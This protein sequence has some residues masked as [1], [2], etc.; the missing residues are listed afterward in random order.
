M[1]TLPRVISS[2]QQRPADINEIVVYRYKVRSPSHVAFSMAK[3]ILLQAGYTMYQDFVQE[4]SKHDFIANFETDARIHQARETWA[5]VDATFYSFHLDVLF[6]AE[7]L[8]YEQNFTGKRYFYQLWAELDRPGMFLSDSDCEGEEEV[9]AH[10]VCYGCD[11]PYQNSW[12]NDGYCT[13]CW[14]E[15]V[16]YETCVKI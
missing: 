1:F 9:K 12:T 14:K 3:D 11:K 16:E 7:T 2:R 8:N 15:R 10:I 6:M 13:P 5:I 4:D